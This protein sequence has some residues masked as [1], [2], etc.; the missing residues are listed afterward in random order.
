MQVRAAHADAFDANQ[1]VVGTG[2][3]RRPVDKNERAGLFA[4]DS[5][6]EMSFVLAL[7]ECMLVS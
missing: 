2:F 6:H 3:G 1:D 7:P 4:D 5:F